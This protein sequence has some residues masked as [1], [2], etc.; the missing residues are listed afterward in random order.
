[1]VC[2][3]FLNK[4]VFK[5]KNTGEQGQ[6]KEDKGGMNSDGKRHDLSGEHGIQCTD[7]VLWNCAPEICKIL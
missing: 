5:N 7:G 6:V 3:L 4:L 2:E 1:M